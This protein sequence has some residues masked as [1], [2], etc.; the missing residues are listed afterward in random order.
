M[1]IYRKLKNVWPYMG[2]DI[3]K[4]YPPYSFHPMSAKLHEDIDGGIQVITF[5]AYRTSFKSSVAL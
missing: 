1:T 2:L 3:S 5:L 4:R